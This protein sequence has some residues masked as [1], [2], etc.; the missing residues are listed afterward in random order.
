MSIHPDHMTCT[1]G[2]FLISYRDFVGPH[3]E[4]Y[5][6]NHHVQ[7]SCHS[8]FVTLTIGGSCRARASLSTGSG[9]ACALPLMSL[10]FP[11]LS[12]SLFRPSPR[13]RPGPLDPDRASAR[14]NGEPDR[15]TPPVIDAMPRQLRPGSLRRIPYRIYG[16][17]M[18]GRMPGLS[19][20]ATSSTRELRRESCSTAP[21][22]Q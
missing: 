6:L 12:A 11:R 14:R 1:P 5:G 15:Y 9:D 22:L 2:R 7:S 16:E 17:K 8:H 3:I 10:R 20:H 19:E 13:Y 21:L 4:Y 18:A